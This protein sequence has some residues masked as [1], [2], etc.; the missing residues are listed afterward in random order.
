MGEA[1]EHVEH[2]VGVDRGQHQVAGERGLHRDLGG[3]AVADLADHDLV[4][5]VAQDRAQAFRERETL[6]LVHRNLQDAGQLVL[7][8]VFDGDDLFA[9][10]VD[11]GEGRVQGRGL[12]RAGRAGYQQHAVG[13]LGQHAQRRQRWRIEAQRFQGQRTIGLDHGALV[14][15][16][17]H[18]VFTVDAWHDRDAQIDLAPV[19]LDAEAAVLGN[20]ALGDVE[21]G[22]HLQARD[23]V[24]GQL[25]AADRGCMIEHAVDAVL[26]RDAG[27]RAFQVDVGSTGL[28]GVVQRR[29]DQLD[30]WTARF[31]HRR[32][33]QHGGGLAVA[34]GIVAGGREGVDRARRRFLA[35]QIGLDVG[36]QRQ[37]QVQRCARRGAG[38]AR[39]P[40]LLVEVEGVG[41]HT[42][43]L[44]TGAAQQHAV[45]RHG[46]RQRQQIESRFLAQHLGRFHDRQAKGLG[47]RAHELARLQAAEGFEFGHERAVRLAALRAR[48]RQHGCIEGN[49]RTGRAHDMS[50][51]RSKIGMYSSTTMA[52]T[53]R[54]MA[55]I[56]SGSKVRVKRSIQRL[57]SPS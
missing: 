7:D 32:E 25:D 35:R 20:A 9:A 13:F 43:D 12:A 48:A 33:R 54:P 36:L 21:F 29:V 11:F 30:G 15:D 26:H 28:Q 52:P 53:T 40:G 4:G 38:H 18:R 31:R 39:Q 41:D 6:L 22:Q 16:T 49:R 44:A 34:A 1:A 17:D 24:L 56:S 8:R 3:L 37:A 23:D 5:V 14:Q 55:A 51:A 57:I 47:Q 10:I 19:R 42:G 27:G 2:V 45:A 46:L 50:P